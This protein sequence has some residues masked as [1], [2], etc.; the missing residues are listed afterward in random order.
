[1]SIVSVSRMSTAQP[2]LYIN[3]VGVRKLRASAEL[4]QE[5]EEEETRG[6]SGGRETARRYTR[7]TS[8]L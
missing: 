1:M 4:R 3:D 8:E 5:Q 2:M 7:A 6:E